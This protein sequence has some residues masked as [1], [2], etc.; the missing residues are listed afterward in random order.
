MSFKQGDRDKESSTGSS[1]F[2]AAG[3]EYVSSMLN[4][5]DYDFS[6]INSTN[7]GNNLLMS[8]KNMYKLSIRKHGLMIQSLPTIYTLNFS[9]NI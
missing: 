8:Q 3:L 7:Y 4:R 6:K 9:M 2:T 5:T 1:N